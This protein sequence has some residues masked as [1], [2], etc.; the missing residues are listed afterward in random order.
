MGLRELDER[1]TTVEAEE[2]LIAAGL[3]RRRRKG[4]RDMLSAQILLQ[5]FLDA[6]CPA[7][8]APATSLTDPAEGDD[9]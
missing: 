3:K 6:G 5:N 8:E 4:L 9:S 2:T 7:A 1:Y